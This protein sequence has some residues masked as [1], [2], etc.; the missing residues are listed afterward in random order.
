MD[1][2]KP[3]LLVKETEEVDLK[4]VF[5]QLTSVLLC[6]KP[7]KVPNRFTNSLDLLILRLEI[8]KDDA[9][10]GAAL[11]KMKVKRLPDGEQIWGLKIPAEIEEEVVSAIAERRKR[12][13]EAEE[14]E[15]DPEDLEDPDEQPWPRP[16]PP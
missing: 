15:L 16:M 3:I 10:L 9:Q 11:E 1:I 5:V 7:T 14:G 8:Q 6:C 13:E 12:R 4:E 2:K